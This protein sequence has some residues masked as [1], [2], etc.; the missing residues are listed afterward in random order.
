MCENNFT[1]HVSRTTDNVRELQTSAYTYNRSRNVLNTFGS[2][3]K[4]LGIGGA[5]KLMIIHKMQRPRDLLHTVNICGYAP[6]IS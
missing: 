4:N 3:K 2:L 1:Y 6:N 5:V